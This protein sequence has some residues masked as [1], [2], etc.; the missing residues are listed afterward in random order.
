MGL[1]VA[2]RGLAAKRHEETFGGGSN[3]PYVDCGGLH[4]IAKYVI[5]V[6]GLT[7]NNTR[8]IQC[9]IQY[10]PERLKRGQ[11]IRE[12]LSKYRSF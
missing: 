12:Y 2:G 9:I 11:H 4:P 6:K 8:Y 10:V 7:L 5:E 1:G 3:V